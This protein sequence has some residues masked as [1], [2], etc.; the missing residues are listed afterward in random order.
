[1]FEVRSDRVRSMSEKSKRVAF[2]VSRLEPS[3][4]MLDTKP[5]IE[6]RKTP[7]ADESDASPSTLVECPSWYYGYC[8]HD[9]ECKIEQVELETGEL[10][11]HAV[12]LSDIRCYVYCPQLSRKYHPDLHCVDLGLAI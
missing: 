6:E 10:E 7:E 5:N 3:S 8:M 2:T 9:G 12:R 1:M 11:T 4:L